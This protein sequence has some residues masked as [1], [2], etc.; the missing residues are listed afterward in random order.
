MTVLGI[1]DVGVLKTVDVHLEPAV[2]IDVHVGDENMPQAIS[3]T[4][5]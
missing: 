4:I 5:L 3:T 1:P 2:G